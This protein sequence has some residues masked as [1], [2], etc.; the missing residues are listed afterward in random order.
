MIDVLMG[1]ALFV[2]LILAIGE[3]VVLVKTDKFWPLSVDDYV[4]CALLTYSAL[5]L[6][7]VTSQYLMLATWSLMTGN[8][9][10]MLFTRMDPNG[11]TRERLGALTALLSSSL[12][13]AVCTF[14]VITS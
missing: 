4:A 3:T 1:F 13:G 7:Q 5:T 8:L 10:A 2:A 6:E 11:G 9:Y 12:A 14:L